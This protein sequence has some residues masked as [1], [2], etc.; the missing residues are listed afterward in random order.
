MPSI[1][2]TE[3][4]YSVLLI[5]QNATQQE[6]KKSYKRLAILRHPD[7]NIGDFIN[8]SAAFKKVCFSYFSHKKLFAI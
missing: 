5:N 3:S 1:S 8:A 7:K 2:D 6:I 4:Y